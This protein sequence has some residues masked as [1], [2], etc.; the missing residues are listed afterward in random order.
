L[1]IHRVRL[2][3]TSQPRNCFN[4]HFTV[5]AVRAFLLCWAVLAMLTYL[6]MLLAVR[7]PRRRL[8][9]RSCHSLK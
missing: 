6:C 2:V 1:G 4:V 7:W 5:M 8:T 9:A 3:A